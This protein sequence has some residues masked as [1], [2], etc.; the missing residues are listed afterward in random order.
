MNNENAQN[1]GEP[2][3]P[4]S[5]SKA[6][7]LFSIGV[8]GRTPFEKTLVRNQHSPARAHDRIETEKSLVRKVCK[9]KQIVSKTPPQGAGCGSEMLPGKHIVRL[10]EQIRDRGQQRRH[11]ND[12]DH[13]EAPEPGR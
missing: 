11:E 13:R 10:F 4:E 8:V 2:H 1:G 9:R 7:A 12:P 5:R 6:R 3:G